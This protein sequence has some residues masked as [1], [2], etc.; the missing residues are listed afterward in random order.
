M[1]PEHKGFGGVLRLVAAVAIGLALVQGHVDGPPTELLE[2]ERFVVHQSHFKIVEK[3]GVALENDVEPPPVLDVLASWVL[4]T[5]SATSPRRNAP[6][7]RETG[8]H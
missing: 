5:P 3:E 7:K 1:G 2:N 6:Q 8:H 4:P